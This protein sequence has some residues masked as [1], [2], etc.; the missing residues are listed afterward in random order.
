MERQLARWKK[1]RDQSINGEA[2]R[3]KTALETSTLK[4]TQRIQ[5]ITAEAD[6]SYYDEFET[7]ARTIKIQS[8]K[9]QHTEELRLLE[10]EHRLERERIE[11]AMA[12]KVVLAVQKRQAQHM[13]EQEL[14]RIKQKTDEYRAR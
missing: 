3:Y 6:T 9:E 14:S 4:E 10:I 1:N 8:I 13:N 12:T 7:E 2:E 5:K 11:E